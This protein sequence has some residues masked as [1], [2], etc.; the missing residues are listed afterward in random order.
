MKMSAYVD[1]IKLAVTGGLLDLEI[2]DS[3]IQQ[4]VNSAMRELQR[5]ICSTT[6][7]TTPYEK[8]LDMKK[9]N[10]NSISRVYR[11]IGAG[12][13]A[14]G[15]NDYSDPM[16]ASLFQIASGYGNL[17]NLNDFTYNYASWNTL[18]Q[19]RNTISTDL[20]FFYDDAKQLL[21]INTNR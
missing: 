16:Q 13:S 6:L 19:I 5:Y 2:P 3:T 10:P 11:A 14:G 7:I 21:Y 20:D 9:Y 4:I 1:E 8:S 18:Q 15:Q 17:Y 12:L